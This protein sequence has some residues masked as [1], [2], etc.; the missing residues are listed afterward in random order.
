M[1]RNIKVFIQPED[2]YQ[3]FLDHKEELTDKMAVIAASDTDDFDKKSFLFMSNEDGIL[4][5][6]LESPETIIDS[7]YCNKNE[8][9]II[10]NKFL[11]KLSKLTPIVLYNKYK[12]PNSFKE[13]T[14]EITKEID[15]YLKGLSKHYYSYL[16]DYGPRNDGYA[17]AIRSPGSTKGYIH[18]DKNNI[19][20]E[21]K[22][23]ELE[24]FTSGVTEI[25][26]EFLGY[27]LVKEVNYDI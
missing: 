11:D 6:S 24:Y 13:Y 27:E 14:C 26:K 4:Y 25:E 19:I 20:T 18:T 1:Y 23:G 21:I 8:F 2:V 22:I 15:K 9:K 16:V 3:Y 17:Y 10:V 12:Y 5:L 7:E